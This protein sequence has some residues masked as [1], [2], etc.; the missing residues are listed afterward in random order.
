[1]RGGPLGLAP[2]QPQTIRVGAPEAAD[3]DTSDGMVER[4][5]FCLQA[6]LTR[7]QAEELVSLLRRERVDARLRRLDGNGTPA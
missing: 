4:V 3:A 7:G 2:L 5:P 1:M 6:G